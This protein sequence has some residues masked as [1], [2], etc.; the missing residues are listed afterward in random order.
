MEVRPTKL[1]FARRSFYGLSRS[2][3]QLLKFV[4]RT[5]VWKLH[6]MKPS[7][8][9]IVAK[10]HDNRRTCIDNNLTS[11]PQAIVHRYCE[12]LAKAT[13]YATLYPKHSL[14]SI[15]FRENSEMRTSIVES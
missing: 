9:K 14:P 5:Q 10:H 7:N 8:A 6:A 3:N 1:D 12:T 13:A 2:I 11:T 15:P 4:M